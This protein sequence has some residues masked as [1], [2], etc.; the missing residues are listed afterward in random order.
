MPILA[1][2][3]GQKNYLVELLSN[4]SPNNTSVE[5]SNIDSDHRCEWLGSGIR[6]NHVPDEKSFPLCPQ[7]VYV[8]SPQ[9]ARHFFDFSHF[10][11][12]PYTIH[13]Q[14]YTPSQSKEEK[15]LRYQE[16]GTTE[17]KRKRH[18]KP[19]A[20]YWSF[21]PFSQTHDLHYK[22][23]TKHSTKTYTHIAENN[24][25]SNKPIFSTY[26]TKKKRLFKL[27]FEGQH[28]ITSCIA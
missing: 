27:V 15:N 26:T 7:I 28:K 9:I 21:E 5:S 14:N 11:S 6:L 13:Q 10:L 1:K 20:K 17:S 12:W 23:L 16:N 8:F 19:Q 2:R 22:R 18:P 25:W 3:G 4:S 24:K